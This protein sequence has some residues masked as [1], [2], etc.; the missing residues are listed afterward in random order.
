ML[1]V[2][3]LGL[4]PVDA[5]L[6]EEAARAASSFTESRMCARSS[7]TKTFSSK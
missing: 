6:G 7:G 5:L 3:A 1:G 4:D 2:L